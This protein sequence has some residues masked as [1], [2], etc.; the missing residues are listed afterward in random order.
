MNYK[1]GMK[2]VARPAWALPALNTCLDS[3]CLANTCYCSDT[4]GSSSD[5]QGQM[6]QVQGW[7]MYHAGIDLQSMKDP[8]GDRSFQRATGLLPWC[9]SRASSEHL[10]SVVLWFLFR[11][12]SSFFLS[13]SCTKEL[14]LY[15][16]ICLVLIKRKC[17]CG[18]KAR[19]RKK[20]THSKTV[21]LLSQGQA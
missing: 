13:F 17:N 12:F 8:G 5:S 3:V 16:F 7:V 20:L 21:L 18:G 11:S 6:C 1:R 14:S 10:E 4:D 2:L 9:F 15:L 19:L